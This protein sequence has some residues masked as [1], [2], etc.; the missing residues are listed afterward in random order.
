MRHLATRGGESEHLAA[1]LAEQDFAILDDAVHDL[2]G[3]ER[4]C[5]P[6]RYPVRDR[7][8]LGSLVVRKWW[9]R[10]AGDEVGHLA[11]AG[12]RLQIVELHQRADRRVGHYLRQYALLEQADEPRSTRNCVLAGR[13]SGRG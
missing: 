9:W 1:D 5:V 10:E 12:G 4:L 7:H 8:S 6:H 3:S 13:R 2:A 11:G